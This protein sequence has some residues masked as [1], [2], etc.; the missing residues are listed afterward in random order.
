MIDDSREDYLQ[1]RELLKTADHQLYHLDWADSLEK[2]ATL[3]F[4]ERYHLVLVDNYLGLSSGLEF[5]RRMETTGDRTPCVLLSG[6]DTITLDPGTLQLISRQR[7]GFLSKNGLDAETLQRVITQ[8]AA[9]PLRTLV[10]D[11]Q[12]D[13]FQTIRCILEE[14]HQYRFE[15]DWS[16]SFKDAGKHITGQKYDLFV[17]SHN[18]N[19]SDSLLRE[20]SR[21]AELAPHQPVI[22]LSQGAQLNVDEGFM[23]LVGRGNVGF[24]S[25]AR[26]TTESLG[27]LVT[28]ALLRR[29]ARL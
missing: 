4:I 15:I 12:V 20:V 7:V 23:R 13:D 19:D 5:L 28:F 2:A 1:V 18:G 3:Q 14:I 24:L 9:H 22:L 21:V 6:Q 8:H 29:K 17:V 27:N 10:V 11:D 26:L 25:K 16:T